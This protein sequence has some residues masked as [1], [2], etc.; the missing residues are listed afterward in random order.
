MTSE[1]TYH[2]Y[3]IAQLRDFML[4]NMSNGITLDMISTAGG[5][6]LINNPCAKDDDVVLSIAK[7]NS[8][9]VGYTAVFGEDLVRPDMRLFWGSSEWVDERLRGKGIGAKMMQNIKDA[10]KDVYFGL[11]SSPASVKLDLKQGSKVCFYNKYW[12]KLSS[13][14]QGLRAKIKSAYIRRHNKRVLRGLE[15]ISF[16]VRYINFIDDR[17]YQFIRKNSNADLFLRKQEMFNWMLTYPYQ[18]ST[19]ADERA[20]SNACEYWPDANYYRWIAVDILQYGERIGVVLLTKRNDALTIRYIY[21]DS[22]HEKDVYV[23]ILHVIFKMGVVNFYHCS[24]SFAEFL[25]HVGIKQMNSKANCKQISFTYP[26]N[27]EFDTFLHIQGG[28]GDMFC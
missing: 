13:N 23:A 2:L 27:F 7:Q 28:D 9:V 18:I 12:Y 4:H 15:S 6:A 11:E 14:S 22:M 1:I 17:I 16:D 10:V 19:Y 3:T 5:Y 24:Q 26:S 20:L 25:M 8:E 21:Y